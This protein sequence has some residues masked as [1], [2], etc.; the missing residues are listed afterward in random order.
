MLEKKLKHK[1]SYKRNW[2]WKKNVDGPE[3]TPAKTALKELSEI[4]HNIES[5]KNEMMES[6]PNLEKM[7]T[8]HQGTEEEKK[9]LIL[10]HKLQEGKLY[11][12]YSR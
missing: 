6:D 1:W 3:V 8:I 10:Y 7:K 11:S 9:I 12:N 5:A 4:F 2:L